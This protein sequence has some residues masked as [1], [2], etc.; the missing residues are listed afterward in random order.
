VEKY[1]HIDSLQEVKKVIPAPNKY[2]INLKNVKPRSTI[3]TIYPIKRERFMKIVKDGKP[4]PAS[5]ESPTA[6]QKTQW[7]P[8]K[9]KVKMRE[10]K[11]ALLFLDSLIKSKKS[12]PGVG[13][14]KNLEK[15]FDKSVRYRTRG[16]F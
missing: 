8:P 16:R 15:A 3:T 10:I 7:S 11:G 14:Y 13:H 5:Y 1:S 6:I 2:N 12:V 4:G 9:G